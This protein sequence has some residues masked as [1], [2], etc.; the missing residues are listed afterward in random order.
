MAVTPIDIPAP[1]DALGSRAAYS[2]SLLISAL[3]TLWIFPVVFL[4]GDGPFWQAPV[5]GDSLQAVFGLNYFIADSWRF[6][7]TFS[8]ILGPDG[9]SVI[10]ASAPPIIALIDKVVHS[11]FGVRVTL[12]GAWYGLCYLL[13]GPGFVFLVRSV[14]G[15]GDQAVLAFDRCA[16]SHA[17]PSVRCSSRSKKKR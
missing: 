13:Q 3:I 4:L 5:G 2:L 1:S 12:F 7:L 10:Y 11:V 6:P 15:D 9:A 17:V 14:E 8:R 16:L